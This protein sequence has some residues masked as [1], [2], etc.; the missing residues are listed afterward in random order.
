MCYCHNKC[1]CT[2]AHSLH[3]CIC[4]WLPVCVIIFK[5]LCS[6]TKWL[7]HCNQCAEIHT[8]LEFKNLAF[9]EVV[10]L[11]RN[12]IKKFDQIFKVCSAKFDSFNQELQVFH[13]I[14]KLS[15]Y[16]VKFKF[17]KDTFSHKRNTL[18]KEKMQQNDY[19]SKQ[20]CSYHQL[21]KKTELNVLSCDCLSLNAFIWSVWT[22]SKWYHFNPLAKCVYLS[23][24]NAVEGR[25]FAANSITLIW[26]KLLKNRQHTKMSR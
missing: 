8:L 15:K 17:H 11:T 26:V 21:E 4:E 9:V 13:R 24:R 23:L 12:Q 5:W 2:F 14:S 7:C 19:S 18:I 6:L 10:Y 3:V 1:L 22:H 25:P 16:L 20:K